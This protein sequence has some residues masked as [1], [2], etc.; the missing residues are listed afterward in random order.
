VTGLDGC[1]YKLWKTLLAKYEKTKEEGKRG[2]DIISALEMVFI[3]IQQFGVDDQTEFAHGWMCL[4][5]KK[6]DPMDIS[7]YRSITLLNTDYKI[8]TKTLALQLVDPI[9]N[10]VHLDQAGF[11]PRRIIFDHIRL[12]MTI[13]NYAKVMEED[14]VI[15]ALDQ[16]KVYDK[17]RHKYL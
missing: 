11:I 15:I 1:P 13:I 8:L 10:L 16:E 3:D 7:N 17:I 12:T 5:Y 6:K 14:G 4:I 9:H 2:F